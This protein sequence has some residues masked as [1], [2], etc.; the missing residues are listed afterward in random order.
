MKAFMNLVLNEIIKVWKQ[1]GY[2]VVIFIM[3][4]LTLLSPILNLV[5]SSGFLSFNAEDE[6]ETY[7]EWADDSDGVEYE[8]FNA[9]AEAYKFFIDNDIEKGFL[10]GSIW[11]NLYEPYKYTVKSVS[12]LTDLEKAIYMLQVYTFTSIELTLYV[13]THP[14]NKEAHEMLKKINAE[15]KKIVDFFEGKYSALCSSSEK[16]DGF[17]SYP[18]PWGD[19]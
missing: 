3:L 18:F 9:Y 19:K 11:S 13:S 5:L 10:K 16:L 17:F 14:N 7:R 6:Y 4:G 12:K 15:K 8:Y 2:R 1:T